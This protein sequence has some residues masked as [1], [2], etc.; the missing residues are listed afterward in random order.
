MGTIQRQYTYTAGATIAAD[1][2]NA[3]EDAL[4]TLVNGQLDNN[5]ISP[6]RWYC[7]E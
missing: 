3:N 1:Q 2:N 4:Y 7:G 6:N 5:N